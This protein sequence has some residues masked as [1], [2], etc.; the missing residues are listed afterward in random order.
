MRFLSKV[1]LIFNCCFLIEAILY[2]SKDYIS[3]DKVPH[4]LNILKGSIVVLGEIAWIVNLVFL[5]FVLINLMKH[6][7]LHIPKGIIIMNLLI[8]IFQVYYFLF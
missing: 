6:Q 2:Y 5:L 1:A 3:E 7:K 4:Q 8:F